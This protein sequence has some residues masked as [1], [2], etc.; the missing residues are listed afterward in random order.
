M[1]QVWIG[2]LW[3][4]CRDYNCA[5]S[6]DE[7]L[8]GL[9]TELVSSCNNMSDLDHGHSWWKNKAHLHTDKEGLQ[10]GLCMNY[11]SS[12]SPLNNHATTVYIEIRI[13][14][15][16]VFQNPNLVRLETD[17]KIREVRGSVVG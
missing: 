15:L 1:I 17:T 4:V 2:L 9:I 8:A 10:V 14:L 11:L 7:E 5:T 16:L 6:C 3:T 12:N 13:Q